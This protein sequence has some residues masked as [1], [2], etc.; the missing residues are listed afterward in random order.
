MTKKRIYITG[1]SSG[2]GLGLAQFYARRGDDVV[3]L[4]RDPVKLEAAITSCAMQA[5]HDD[6]V[7][8]SESVD[9]TAYERLPAVMDQIMQR[10][11]NPDLLILCAGVAGN[12]MFLDTSAAEF[13]RIVDINLAGSR[14]VARAVL[15]AMLERGSGQVAFVSSMAGLIGLY[16]YTA[17]SASKFAVTGLVQALRQELLGSGVSV[18]LICPP[19]VNTPMIAA[20]AQSG[21]PQTRFLKDMV[22]TLEPEVVA[23]KIARGLDKRKPIV[24]PGVRANIMVWCARHFPELFA[25]GSELLLRW[26]FGVR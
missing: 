5:L 7:I 9:I 4:A 13:D 24:I 12:K 1:G 6:Q 3:L 23:Q 11:G 16:G 17:Y 14:E 25:R 18:H 22:G 19:E 20:E 8:T 10:H 26:K 21:L 15:T 2:I